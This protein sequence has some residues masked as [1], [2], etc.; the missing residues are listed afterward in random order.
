MLRTIVCIALFPVGP[1]VNTQQ[2]EVVFPPPPIQSVDFAGANSAWLI[3][4]QGAILGT[5]NGGKSWTTLLRRSPAAKPEQISFIDSRVAWTV[6][7]E[8]KVLR[9][10]DCG[11]SWT[12]MGT[13]DYSHS[14][15]VGPF[16]QI[17][18]VDGSNGW[19]LD[20]FSVLRTEDAGRTWRRSFPFPLETKGEEGD[21]TYRGFFFPD[22]KTAWVSGRMGMVYSTR[23]GGKTWERHT[24]V[25]GQSIVFDMFF[26]DREHG[27][28]CGSPGGAVYQTTDGG[29]TWAPKLVWG[30]EF[31]PQSIQF[32][33][34]TGWTAG[35]AKLRDSSQPR[36]I[37]FNTRDA[38][39]TWRQVRCPHNER[40][41]NRVHFV[42]ANSGWIA[43][44]DAIY[45]TIDAGTTWRKVFRSADYQ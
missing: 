30:V 45:R 44:E 11:D 33:D 18:F 9:T 12:A 1:M 34:A 19:I 31:N 23:D 3:T 6:D 2:P 28:A 13:L 36:A 8:G 14:P 41:V 7:S 10:L 17:K 22:S 4:S 26:T 42:D 40:S 38:G 15:F 5:R 24:I 16:Q 39:Q 37:L 35:S 25:K 43:T 32:I 21:L 27:W 29:Q 20:A